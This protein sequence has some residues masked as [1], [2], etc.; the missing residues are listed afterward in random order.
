M[1]KPKISAWQVVQFECSR[2][3]E[4]N[5]AGG[6]VTPGDTV[7]CKSC[8]QKFTVRDLYCECRPEKKPAKRKAK[9]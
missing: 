5:T 4:E 2:C 9:A 7:A 8:G 1:A 3:G 6:W